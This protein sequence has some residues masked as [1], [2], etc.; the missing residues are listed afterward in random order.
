MAAPI[1]TLGIAGAGFMGSGIAES[2]AR[3]G[4]TVR[5]Y[6]PEPAALEASEKRIDTSVARAVERG[7]LDR[8]ERRPCAS[9]SPGTPTWARSAAPS[10]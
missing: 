10:W 3:A 1:E 5:L 9:E 2:A 4:L 7:K 8:A 6:E